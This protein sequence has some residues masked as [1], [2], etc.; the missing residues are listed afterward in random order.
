MW[1]KVGVAALLLGL[2]LGGVIQLVLSIEDSPLLAI[3]FF[4]AI[5]Y[6]AYYILLKYFFGEE[7]KDDKD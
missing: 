6:F 4:I 5:L 7:E 3:I 1:E 2:L